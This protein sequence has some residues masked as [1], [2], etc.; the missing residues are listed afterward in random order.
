MTDSAT[1]RSEIVAVIH[2]CGVQRGKLLSEQ[3]NLAVMMAKNITLLREME[4]T[5]AQAE[6]MLKEIDAK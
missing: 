5:L 3:E 6:A 1:V 4:Q 2:D